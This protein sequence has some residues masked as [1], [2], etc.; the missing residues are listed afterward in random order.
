ME[1]ILEANDIVIKNRDKEMIAY[2]DIESIII[3]KSANMDNGIPIMGFEYYYFARIVTKQQKQIDI[4]C[5]VSRNIDKLLKSH[6]SGVFF[7]RRH[8]PFAIIAAK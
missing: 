1:V 3:Y 4:T 6:V 8:N 7:E 5:L 2:N